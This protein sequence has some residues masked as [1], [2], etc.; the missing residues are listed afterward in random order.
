MQGDQKK[1]LGRAPASGLGVFRLSECQPG[2]FFNLLHPQVLSFI[3][4][5][6]LIF[7]IDPSALLCLEAI[8]RENHPARKL[9]IP[10][11]SSQLLTNRLIVEF[12][13]CVL[14]K[15]ISEFQSRMERHP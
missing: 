11:C 5:Y 10:M 7:A 14:E 1:E 4:K 15:A 9:V 8:Q 13:V 6:Q 3:A 2:W 12:R